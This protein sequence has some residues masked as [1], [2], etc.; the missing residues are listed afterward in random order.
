MVNLHPVL[1]G[2]QADGQL[3]QHADVF[4]RFGW[5]EMKKGRS[6]YST[7][8]AVIPMTASMFRD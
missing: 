1:D 6:Q 4:L 5:L 3:G 8:T 2:L 7:I